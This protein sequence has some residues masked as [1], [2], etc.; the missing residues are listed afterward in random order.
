MVSLVFLGHIIVTHNW[1][2]MAHAQARKHRQ[3]YGRLWPPWLVKRRQRELYC[4]PSSIDPGTGRKSGQWVTRRPLRR[5]VCNAFNCRIVTGVTWLCIGAANDPS[6][7]TIT[8]EKAST[9]TLSWLKACTSMNFHE[10]ARMLF[11][12]GEGAFSMIVN[13][14]DRL[15]L[16]FVS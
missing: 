15:Q 6:V 1:R 16:Y 2:L 9:R 13:P 7:F 10:S 14:I 11:Q 5:S 12:P 3:R 4:H 8:A